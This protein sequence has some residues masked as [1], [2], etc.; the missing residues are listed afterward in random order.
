MIGAVDVGGT[1]IA[2]GLVTLSG[3]L[4]DS[5]VLP[6]RPAQPYSDGLKEVVGALRGLLQKHPGRLLGIGMGVTGRIEPGGLLQ[7]NS[8]LPQWSGQNPANDLADLFKVKAGIENDA[9]AAALAEARWGAGIGAPRLIYVTVS[10]GIGGGMIFDGRLYRGVA[11]AHPEIG[12][13]VIDPSGPACFCGAHGCWER[14]ASGSALAEWARA[15][16]GEADW[17]ARNVC[18]Q[19]GR[20]HP[21]AQQAVKREAQY[22]GIGLAN[23]ITIFAPDCIALGGGLMQRWELFREGVEDTLR[24]QC[25]LAPWQKTRLVLSQLQ[26][27]GL[28]GAA[29]TWIQHYGDIHDL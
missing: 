26:H 19:A 4:L 3:E 24:Q 2:V 13:H 18:D 14:M 29:S 12:H 15:N 7:P 16:G 8:F 5:V 10:T 21:I 23:L 9:D 11:G 22:L 25:G 27:P 28:V 1:K 6:T 20:G 17:D